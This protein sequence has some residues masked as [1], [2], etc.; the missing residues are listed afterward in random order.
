MRFLK[1]LEGSFRRKMN[2]SFITI[3]TPTFN[4]AYRLPALYNSLLQQTSKNFEWIIIDDCSTDDTEELI[5]SW[6]KEDKL[7]LTYIKQEKNGGKH[8]CINKAVKIAQTELFFIVDSDDFLTDD[9]VEQ[10]EKEWTNCKNK[11]KYAGLCFRRMKKNT[12]DFSNKKTYKILGD[13]FPEYRC[14]GTS[15]DI[16]Y[17]WNC[18]VDKAEVYKVAVLKRFPFPE[19][20]NEN[21]CE[22]AIVWFNIAKHKPNLLL[23]INRGIYIGEYLEDGLS[24]NL[25]RKFKESPKATLKYFITLLKIP[26][27]WKKGNAP[28]LI[29][30]SIYFLYRIIFRRKD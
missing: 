23:C 21:F 12:F 4:R 18:V 22:E 2:K 19:Y 10:I 15:I 14:S 7:K 29:K 13:D 16:A 6:K 26:Y 1:F 28:S 20:K 27:E 8:R 24:A 17:K 25:G 9:A 30:N 11:E 5:N 3:F